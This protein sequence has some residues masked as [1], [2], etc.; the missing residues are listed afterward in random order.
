MD[1]EDVYG[2]VLK[3]VDAFSKLKPNETVFGELCGPGIQKGYSYGLKEHDFAIF[4]VK[5][6]NPDGTQT[7]LSPDEVEAFAKERGFTMVPILYKGAFNK[8]MVYH[9]TKGPSEFND[10]SERVREGVV[11]KAATNYSIEGNK[12]ALKWVSE[13]YLADTTNTDEH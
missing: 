9:L 13:D 11:I 12:Q 3:K 6:L 10:K 4:D 7:W 5:V 2:A 8:E 1:G